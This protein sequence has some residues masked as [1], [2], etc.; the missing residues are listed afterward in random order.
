MK[1]PS[2]PRPGRRSAPPDLFDR[3]FDELI[4]KGYIEKAGVEPNGEVLYRFTEKGL[5]T[6]GQ[7][8]AERVDVLTMGE[9]GRHVPGTVLFA[10]A[11]ADEGLT[12]RVIEPP[13]P[14]G[15]VSTPG[16]D[17]FYFLMTAGNEIVGFQEQRTGFRCH[18]AFSTPERMWEFA[19]TAQAHGWLLQF[20]KG[21]W[22]TLREYSDRRPEI[23]LALDTD[24]IEFCA[25]AEKNIP[26]VH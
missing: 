16:E 7:E 21:F 25:F 9:L 17:R 15:V 3:Y 2:P 18:F 4:E 10:N 6:L 19:R 14:E 23:P 8:E 20:A 13:A 5:R 26:R 1:N 11:E 12:I 22:Y 24:P